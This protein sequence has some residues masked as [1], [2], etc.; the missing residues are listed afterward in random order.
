M[1]KFALLVGVSEYEN[2]FTNLPQ[3]VKDVEAMER[4]LIH[5]DMGNFERANIVLLK[6]PERQTME[7][8]I[9]E[10]FIDRQINDLV[11][12]FF[13]GHGIKDE[14]GK[15][16]LA[17]KNTRKTKQGELVRSSAIAARFIHESM[18][19]SSS[20]RQ[21]VILDSCFSGAF[22]ENLLAKDDGTIDIKEELGG[23][24]RAILTSSASTQYSFEEKG[25]DLS[26]Y[27]RYLIEGIQTGKADRNKDGFISVGELHEY[28]S[29][30][31][32]EIKPTMQPKIYLGQGGDTINLVKI[33][34]GDL[35]EKYREEIS[36][37]CKGKE[38]TFVGRKI[39]DTLRL[40]LGLSTTEAEEIESEVL[41]PLRQE[42]NQKLQQY[43]R[44][45]TEALKQE[46]ALSE[47]E[48][49]QLRK[50]LQQLLNLKD[51]DTRAIE[52]KVRSQI[53]TY[54]Q[55]LLQYEQELN[56]AMRQENPLT[57]T[58]R[59]RLQQ[60]YKQWQ[61]SDRDVAIIEKRTKVESKLYKQKLSQYERSL[62]SAIQKQYPL[63]SKQRR[64]LEKT[65]ANLRLKH[66]DIAV[67]EKKITK[68]IQAYKQN[69]QEYKQL[70]SRAIEN[71]YPISK[72]IRQEL[73][74]FKEVLQLRDE[75]VQ[76]IEAKLVKQKQKKSPAIKSVSVKKN[77]KQTAKK[78]NFSIARRD[79]LQYLIFGGIGISFALIKNFWPTGTTKITKQTKL[80]ENIEPGTTSQLIEKPKTPVEY[81]P[82]LRLKSIEFEIVTVNDRGQIIKRNNKT[83]KQ[84][85][86][87]IGNNINLEM[88][89]IPAGNFLMGSP[90]QERLSQPSE[91]PQRQ[92]NIKAFLMSKYQ[93]TQGQ[94]RTVANLPKI[95]RELDPNPSKFKASRRPVEKI[96]WHD[97]IEFCQR[98]S[99][100]TGRKYRLPTEA[101]WEYA[102]RAGSTTPFYFGLNITTDLAN[103]NGRYPYRQH[104]RY[105]KLRN[106]TTNVGIFPP[107]AFGLHDMHGNVWEWCHDNWHNNYYDA[108]TDGT[109]WLSNNNTFHVMRGGSWSKD[110]QGCRSSSR[111]RSPANLKYETL[112]M[113]V[114]LEA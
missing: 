76:I 10:L 65:K 43:E 1:A 44:D 72:E 57:E 34:S 27:T 3:A 63:S 55:R 45:F 87:N 26:I 90:P 110:A 16:Y 8:T 66:E 81:P 37:Y 95:D 67:I 71:R 62:I 77:L 49:N 17:G 28:V 58:T 6:N 15:L 113:R 73:N 4:V 109:A 84:F 38:I 99:Q 78:T 22:A 20:M 47:E 46:V 89:A 14:N 5:P 92:V 19:R 106:Q 102:V 39:L 56:S 29:E 104:E 98:L 11:L 64:E 41:E 60:M 80:P 2:D 83:A 88:I 69:L 48:L 30:K 50:T 68:K 40:N 101:E 33:S 13:S 31:L 36:Q 107:N 70:L 114:V 42:F 85:S 82:S 75:D 9:E 105:P 112:G 53:E 12:L 100:Q 25:E 93:I 61:L 23:E 111:D 97:A 51:E 108:P 21:I 52:A 86:E 103:F 59:E 18:N 32:Q 54:K 7:E 24:G 35:K 74:Q 96:S 94:W 91:R 79:Y